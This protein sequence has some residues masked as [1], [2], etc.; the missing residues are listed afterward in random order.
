MIA[1]LHIDKVIAREGTRQK[2]VLAHSGRE[3]T[4]SR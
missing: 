3:D 1:I 4:R 2:E